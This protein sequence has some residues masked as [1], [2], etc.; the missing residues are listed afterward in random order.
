[1]YRNVILSCQIPNVFQHSLERGSEPCGSVSPGV[2][3][4]TDPAPQVGVLVADE[5]K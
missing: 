1:M 3:E 2:M 4:S 5:S